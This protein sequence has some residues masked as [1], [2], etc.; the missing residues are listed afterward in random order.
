MYACVCACVCV[1]LSACVCVCVPPASDSTGTVGMQQD[2]ATGKVAKWF[3]GEAHA[4]LSF[5]FL[6]LG[7]FTLDSSDEKPAVTVISCFIPVCRFIE[8][9]VC[10]QFALFCLVDIKKCSFLTSS[11]FFDFVFSNASS[12]LF[13]IFLS[14]RY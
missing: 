10:K 9:N 6:Y 8:G 7:S 12:F 4:L 5:P 3:H 14:S 2:P 11:V 1:H 13:S